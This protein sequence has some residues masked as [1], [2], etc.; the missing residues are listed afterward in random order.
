MHKEQ[1]VTLVELLAVV[2]VLS[3][4]LVVTISYSLPWMGKQTMRSTVHEV[5]GF[6]Q[7][8]RMEAVK[9]NHDCRFVLDTSSGALQVWDTNGTSNSAD[10][11]LLHDHTIPVSVEF[12]RPNS[13]SVVSLQQVST[14]Q[15]Q[16]VFGSEGTVSS[17][18]GDVHLHGSESFGRL[19][20]HAAGGAEISYWNGSAW[21]VGS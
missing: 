14:S 18:A 3:V 1:G 7:L 17:G 2:A 10:D 9:R 5:Y 15:Y 20:V 19:S 13:G 12:A 6:V 8:T 16:T 21:Q 4:S 11:D